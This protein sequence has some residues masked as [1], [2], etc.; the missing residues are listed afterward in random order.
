MTPAHSYERL[1]QLARE[2]STEIADALHRE[3]ARRGDPEGVLWAMLLRPP[4]TCDLLDAD[5]EH[6]ALEQWEAVCRQLDAIPDAHITDAFMRQ[7]NARLEAWPI[8]VRHSIFYDPWNDALKKG[9][10]NRRMH[11]L[12]RLTWY[13]DRDGDVVDEDSVIA[14]C[15]TTCLQDV[16]ELRLNWPNISVRT[17]SHLLRAPYLSQLAQL[18]LVEGAVT[19]VGLGASV[20]SSPHLETLESLVLIRTNLDSDGLRRLLSAWTP[21]RLRSLQLIEN[22][23]DPESMAT[24]ASWKGLQSVESLGLGRNSLRNEG[25]TA[26]LTSPYLAN[27]RHLSLDSTDI[28][29][30]A[31]V[32]LASSPHLAR[33]EYL[34][35]RG[36]TFGPAGLTA[37]A[38][39]QTLTSLEELDIQVTGMPE[40]V[41][42]TL[43]LSDIIPASN[44]IKWVHHM[45]HHGVMQVASALGV[46]TTRNRHRMRN[47]KRPGDSSELHHL[48]HLV[49]EALDPNSDAP[50]ESYHG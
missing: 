36:N 34:N 4:P 21:R 20:A 39:S 42:T 49:Y 45:S 11:V 24:L 41:M 33:L 22:A 7:V 17:L 44:R 26:L 5:S 29:D 23:F 30:P 19:G 47:Y 27:L 14:L 35:L 38:Q 3:A 8:Y 2:G 32:A 9:T 10:L 18:E 31:L 40:H 15:N 1:L 43:A 28:R 46:D 50:E 48:R 13:P 37:L 12:R 16:H 25:I 6:E